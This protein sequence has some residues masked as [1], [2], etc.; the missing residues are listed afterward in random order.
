MKGIKIFIVLFCTLFF[1]QCEKDKTY[2]DEPDWLEPPIYEILQN[3][4]R[5]TNY[6]SCVDKTTYAGLLK[7]G[8]LY[9]VFA[10][11]DDAFSAYLTK[12]GYTSV[13]DIPDEEVNAIVTY[14]M[15]FSK[16]KSENL[17]SL[18]TGSVEKPYE[19]GYAYR[20]KTNY[21]AKVYKDAYYNNRWVID[22]NT[23][24]GT[25]SESNYNYKYLPVFMQSYFNNRG[26]TANDYNIFF[27]SVEYA[28]NK[29]HE[30]GILGNVQDG[31]IVKPNM[32]ARN[33]I[34]HEVS[35][36]NYP[37]DNMEK[38]LED[39]KYTTFRSLLDF[40]TISGD[41]VYKA[42]TENTTLTDLYKL[43]MPDAGIDRVYVKSYDVSTYLFFSPAYEGYYDGTFISTETNGYTLFVPDNASLTDY[44]NNKLLK[45][46]NNLYELPV[47]AITTLINTH[48]SDG[49]VWPSKFRTSQTSTGEYIN[50]VGSTGSA[51]EG[52]NV[53]SQQLAS[54]GFIYEIDHV[55][56][57][58]LFET[59]YGEIFLNPAYFLLNR[60]FINYYNSSLRDDLMKSA[61]TGLPNVRWTL[62]LPSDQLLKADGLAYDET[63][64]SFSNSLIVSA[65][66][67]ERLR[68]LMRMHVF[69][70]YQDNSISSEIA[71]DQA[72]LSQYNGWNFTLSY[73][74]DLIRFKD[75]QIQASGNFDEGTFVTATVV[76]TTE[77]GTVYSI[78]KLLQYSTRETTPGE[79]NGWNQKSLLYYLQKAAVDN[80]NVSNFVQYV[81]TC[82]KAAD[83]EEL[84][85]ISEENYYTVLMVNNTAMNS[86][87]T[88]GYLPT[89]AE[90]EDE[91]TGVAAKEKAANFLRTHF[92]QGKVYPD[93]RLSYIYPY[94]V[95]EPNRSI[96]S[97][98][99]R[100]NNDALGLVNQRTSLVITKNASGALV[101]TPQDVVV[102]GTT[103]VKG[104]TGLA[105]QQVMS[106]NS[107]NG[108][109]DNFRSNRF[110]G[111]SVIHEF[112]GYFKFEV[113]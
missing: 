48:M 45:Y 5:F 22:Q 26:I 8:G 21:Y 4:G 12:K 108:G 106:G 97:T 25:Y 85:G 52:F 91:N 59:V 80:P 107:S 57:S 47:E 60:A 11:N 67:D 111:R 15:V 29:T 99:Y 112:Y 77:N 23:I 109:A 38:L 3:E 39:E 100:I 98:M 35:T 13:D 46:Y 51:Y 64:N 17:G 75:N 70:G 14:S 10:P 68:R 16:W 44:I 71:F 65:T 56:K 103:V 82:L 61:L 83:S 81:E 105:T 113:Q 101:F 27:P 104:T 24:S 37:L 50:G 49:V 18:F 76:E 53:K 58:K 32:I 73:Y 41:Y 28:G 9:T 78:D 94:N 2:F 1:V 66:V 93:D 89:M 96:S 92:I 110:A 7:E 69:E 6:L 63:S 43:I 84:S 55:I 86:A 36:V 54:N 30:N 34:V 95:S 102:N 20:R 90:I 88:S 62:L 31:Q 33:G 79:A 72:G 74:G 40:K 19:S 42:Y 87:R